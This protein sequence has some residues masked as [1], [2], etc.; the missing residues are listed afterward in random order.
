VPV[1]GFQDALGQVVADEAVD[2]ENE[3]FFIMLRASEWP[4]FQEAMYFR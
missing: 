4:G 2:A 1:G 3:D